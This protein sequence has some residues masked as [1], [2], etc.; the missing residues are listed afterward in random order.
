M[1][2]NVLVIHP[3]SLGD[4]LLALP[5]LRALRAGFP[6]HRHALIAAGAVGKLLRACGEI[7]ELIPIEDG[8]LA[9]L[10]AGTGVPSR[11]RNLIGD[12]NLA[13]GW[14]E[15]AEGT[16]APALQA[17]GARRIILRSP[18]HLGFDGL[19]QSDRFLRAV[20]DIAWPAEC[21]TTLTMNDTDVARGR[22]LLSKAGVPQKRVI[23]LHPGSGSRHKCCAPSVFSELCSLL[24][25]GG[26]FPLLL[27][28][29]ADD[30]LVSEVISHCRLPVPI[31]ANLDLITMAAVLM[32]LDLYIGHDSGLTHLA[33]ALHR[34]AIALFGPTPPQRWAPRGS[35]VRILSGGPCACATWAQVRACHDHPCLQVSVERVVRACEE[36]MAPQRVCECG[37]MW[38]GTAPCSNR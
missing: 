20:R 5:A 3:G 33:A 32:H 4:V 22:E 8:I 29:P 2:W 19:H 10:L 36:I 24:A 12:C 16:L 9:S 17:M 38:R 31:I 21:P 34:P 1:G 13:V 7:D 23:G 18:G 26:F 30:D 6:V 15:D 28:G 27:G 11:I 14:M 25:G 35:H 37:P